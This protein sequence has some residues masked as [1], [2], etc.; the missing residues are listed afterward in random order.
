MTLRQSDRSAACDVCHLLADVYAIGLPFE[1]DWTR[2]EMTCAACSFARILLQEL[3][4]HSLTADIERLLQQRDK[5]KYFVLHS[6]SN[7]YK[8]YEQWLPCDATEG[9]TGASSVDTSEEDAKLLHSAIQLQ[10][11][12]GVISPETEHKFATR[13]VQFRSQFARIKS[14][15]TTSTSGSNHS[16]YVAVTKLIDFIEDMFCHVV[17]TTHSDQVC[18]RPAGRNICQQHLTNIY[19]LFL[20]GGVRSHCQFC[21]VLS[22]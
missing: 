9:R 20:P 15:V 7:R 22:C 18:A 14:E 3:M 10:S 5:L 19:V 16:Q 1:E 11:S 21:C 13:A 2:S 8:E 6:I 17:D 12:C 4:Q